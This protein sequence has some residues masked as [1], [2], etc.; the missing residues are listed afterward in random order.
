MSLSRNSWESWSAIE[1]DGVR[2]FSLE[3]IERDPSSNP[4]GHDNWVVLKEKLRAEN[5][6]IHDVIVAEVCIVLN[7]TMPKKFR[8]P[9]FLKVYRTRMF[10]HPFSVILEASTWKKKK[11]KWSLSMYSACLRMS[12]NYF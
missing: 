2:G 10:I 6:M 3:D 11:E 1:S 9:D 5:N 8:V 7:I 4:T 12:K